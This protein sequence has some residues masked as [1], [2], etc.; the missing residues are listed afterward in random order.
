MKRY[1]TAFLAA[2]CVSGAAFAQSSPDAVVRAAVEGTVTA[3]K[4]DPQARGGDMAKITSVV[5]THFVPSTDF[6][7]T[8]RIAIG[9]A[10]ATATPEQQQQLY[11]QFQQLLVRTYAASL[12]Q[13]RD[14]QVTFKFLP[15][16]TAANAKDAV[17]QSHVISNG[18]DDAIDYRLTR[19]ASGWKIYDINMM[20]AWLI[21]VYQTQFADQIAKGGIDGLIK[22]LIDH[23]TRGAG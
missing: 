2:A 22:Y 21:Q 15:S 23:N 6:Q 11:Q 13:L 16:N 7:R 1:L 20:G 9:K 3:M 5:E 14:Q 19:A 18:G 12:S 10:W 8:T 4:A 17:V